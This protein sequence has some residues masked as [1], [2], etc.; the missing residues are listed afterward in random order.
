ML[1]I[2]LNNEYEDIE[3]NENGLSKL[4]LGI[5]TKYRYFHKIKSAGFLISIKQPLLP[6]LKNQIMLLFKNNNKF[7]ELPFYKYIFSQKIKSS[8]FN[9]KNDRNNILK[10]TKNLL[11]KLNNK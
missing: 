11:H 8:Y 2:K 4:K 3:Q 6:Y 5:F 10:N 7:I 9:S 1:K